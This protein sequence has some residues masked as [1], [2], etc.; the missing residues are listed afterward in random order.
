MVFAFGRNGKELCPA[1]SQ[2]NFY[3]CEH[4]AAA[5]N[6]QQLVGKCGVPRL[7]DTGWDLAMGG[8][9]RGVQRLKSTKIVDT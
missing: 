5:K 4:Q 8:F 3:H 1:V 7:S 2:F 6:T 9:W